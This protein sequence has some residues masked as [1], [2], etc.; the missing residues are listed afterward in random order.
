MTWKTA[1]MKLSSNRDFLGT[2]PLDTKRTLPCHP[3]HPCHP[4][5]SQPV[6]RP[7]CSD[8]WGT[9]EIRHKVGDAC[10]RIFDQD[11]TW[12][13]EGRWRGAG[14][15]QS[16]HWLY[17]GVA[18]L[19]SQQT[20]NRARMS[21]CAHVQIGGSLAMGDG[22]TW[23]W[24][25]GDGRWAMGDGGAVMESVWDREPLCRWRQAEVGLA[26][27]SRRERIP[28]ASHAGGA[29]RT[30]SRL[31]LISI[32]IDYRRQSCAI[33]ACRNTWSRN[34]TNQTRVQHPP[35]VTYILL[36]HGMYYI[37]CTMYIHTTWYHG[38]TVIYRSD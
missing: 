7:C 10:C 19:N 26:A 38:T 8:A 36:V 3:C 6:C 16:R 1:T 4:C 24:A 9:E 32:F 25:M 17:L 5:R 28:S 37:V 18:E 2:R 35:A 23:R 20:A 31:T 11:M 29:N 22:R 30:I 27:A 12:A 15:A 34:R 33:Q 14:G 21:T 13:L